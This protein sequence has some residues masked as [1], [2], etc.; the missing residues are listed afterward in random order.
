M[1]LAIIA[2]YLASFD[3]LLENAVL[4]SMLCFSLQPCY[5]APCASLILA[6]QPFALAQSIDK[7]INQA[8]TLLSV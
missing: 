5:F 7:L 2:A 1:T 6:L 8:N 4:T 3:L